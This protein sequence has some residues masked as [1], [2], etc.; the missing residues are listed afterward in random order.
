MIN[1]E[2]Q[3]RQKQI[4]KFLRDAEDDLAK[5]QKEKNLE[6]VATYQFLVNEYE[7]MLEEF[8]DYYKV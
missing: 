1:K 2:A 5:A 3:L 4:I 8:N 6:S 7:Q